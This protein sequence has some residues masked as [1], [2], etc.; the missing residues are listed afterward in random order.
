MNE[1]KAV[2]AAML[3]VCG[4]ASWSPAAA[5]TFQIYR[6]ADGTQFVARFLR[7]GFARASA[8]RWKSGGAGPTP[9]P[10]GLA[11][12]GRRDYAEDRKRRRHHAQARPAGGDPLRTLLER[13]A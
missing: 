13:F 1:C 4:L 12:F 5:Q 7:P 10:V 9:G 2:A 3:A 8:D 6:C 11:L